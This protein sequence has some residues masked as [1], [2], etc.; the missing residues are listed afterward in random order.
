MQHK[1]KDIIDLI[2]D[3]LIEWREHIHAYPE[4]SFKEINTSSY[5]AS[6]LKDMGVPYQSGVAD[7]GVVALI[8]GLNPDKK[9]IALRADIDA[10]PIL[11]ENN[12]SYKSKIDGVMHACGHDVHTACLLG[13][14][15]VLS[16]LKNEFEG[17]IKLIFQ[18]GEE[19]LPGGASLMIEE[20]VLENP[21]VENIFAL[22]VFPSMD[23]GTVGFKTGKYMASC[24]EL[25]ISVN[26]KGGHAALPDQSNNPIMVMADLLTSMVAYV[27]SLSQVN[28]PYIFTFGKLEAKGATNVIPK[29]AKA[30]GTFRTM[31]EEWRLFVHE[32]LNTFINDFLASNGMKGGLSIKKGYPPLINDEHIT[33]NAFNSAVEYLGGEKVE[34]MDIR[35]TSEDFSYYSGEVPACFFRLGVRNKDLDIVHGVH[36][37]KFDIDKRALKVGAGIMAYIAIKAMN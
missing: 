13:A 21:K 22:H 18:P 19:L 4:L 9:C 31:D 8:K 14:A 6:K 11:E 24:D 10:L 17:T 37:P 25:Y 15:K 3:S 2:Y 26:G 27:D 28:S 5:I 36:H 12:T 16:E 33:N 30:E 32:K 23:V 29:L 34:T 20:G 1:I 35:M 7:T